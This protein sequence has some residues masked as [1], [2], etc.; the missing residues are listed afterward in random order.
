MLQHYI[1]R[2]YDQVKKLTGTYTEN[3]QRCPLQ[4]SFIE[5]IKILLLHCK[6]SALMINSIYLKFI[7][8]NII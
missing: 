3:C 7:K 2:E 8:K 6:N 4:I 1:G 5:N